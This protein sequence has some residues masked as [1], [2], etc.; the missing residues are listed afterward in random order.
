MSF[1]TRVMNVIKGWFGVKV[2]ELEQHNIEATYTH[3]IDEQLKAIAQFESAARDVHIE[4]ERLNQ[5]KEIKQKKLEELQGFIEIAM[6]DNDS[7]N[8]IRYLQRINVLEEEI[9]SLEDNISVMSE[10]VELNGKELDLMREELTVLRSEKEESKRLEKLE[11]ARNT[12]AN[13]RNRTGASAN[14][15]SRNAMQE[16]IEK[17]RASLKVDHEIREKSQEEQDRKYK[18]NYKQKQAADQW[19]KMVAKK[20]EAEKEIQFNKGKN[21]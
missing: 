12:A 10:D 16:Q 9:L 7:E 2:E 19:K 13:L 6:Q 21:L 15:R 20:S 4:L 14:S 18:E 11:S 3:L 17:R 1:F 5:E 8:G